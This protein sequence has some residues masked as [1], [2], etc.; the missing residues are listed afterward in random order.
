L[1]FAACAEETTAATPPGQQR[2]R[3]PEAADGQEAA[4]DT[5]L[6][7]LARSGDRAALE[8]LCRRNWRPVFRSFA[9]YTTDPAEAED[10]TQEVFL[11]ALRALPN[12]ADRGVPYTAYLLTIA[13][14]IARDRWRA[15]PF[16]PVPVGDVPERTDPEPG[17]ARRAVESEQRAALARALDSLA[18]DQR[19]VLRLRILERRSSAEVAAVTHRSLAAVR[20]LQVRALAALRA[21]LDDQLGET[22]D[23]FGRN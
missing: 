22:L 9:R 4:D 11:R 15:G 18:P 14:N 16:R 17:P 21:V 20:Q 10:L 7:T 1:D 3:R 23:D 2:P 12:F 5:A 6:L 8:T 13:A 19:R